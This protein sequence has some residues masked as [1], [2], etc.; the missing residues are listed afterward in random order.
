[1][2]QPWLLAE[3]LSP[4]TEKHDREHKLPLYLDLPSL[5]VLLL[6][7]Q[8]RMRVEVYTRQPEGWLIRILRK[9][10]DLLPNDRFS[11]SLA[12]LYEGV[13]LSATNP[14]I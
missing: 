2:R 1:M 4:G 3:I 7:S 11:L 6:I 13:E 10:D 9:P 14:F 5:Q 8:D 12:E